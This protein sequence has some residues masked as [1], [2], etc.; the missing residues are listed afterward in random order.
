M[1]SPVCV[2]MF[3]C[4]FA[5]LRKNFEAIFVSRCWIMEYCYEENTLNFGVDPSRIAGW[6]PVWIFDV[7]ICCICLSR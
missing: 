2:H 5:G 6:Q 4:L 1:Y 7:Q 3:V